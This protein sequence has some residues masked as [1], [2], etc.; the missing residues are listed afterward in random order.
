MDKE[1]IVTLPCDENGNCPSCG[2]ALNGGVYTRYVKDDPNYDGL[3][4]CSAA[5]IQ[6]FYYI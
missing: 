4:L 1:Y 3:Q 2:S 5:C 6:D